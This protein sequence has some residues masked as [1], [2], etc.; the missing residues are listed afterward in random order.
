VQVLCFGTHYTEKGVLIS[1]SDGTILEIKY[2]KNVPGVWGISV[3][4]KGCLFD[5]FEPCTDPNADLYSDIVYL[6]DGIAV[7]YAATA[8]WNE[9]IEK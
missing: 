2:C 8:Y 6:K 9:V 4:S 3:F 7:A 5:R 1:C